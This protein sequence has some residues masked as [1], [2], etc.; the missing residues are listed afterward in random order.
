MFPPPVQRDTAD[1]DHRRRQ[2][3]DVRDRRPHGGVSILTNLL[4]MSHDDLVANIAV[5]REGVPGGRAPGRRPRHADAPHVRRRRRS[6]RCGAK[7][8][9]AVPRLPADV[10]RPHQQGAVGDGP[11][12]AKPD[13]RRRPPAPRRWTS[14]SSSPDEM[15]AI[16]DH[17]FERYFG[18]AGLFG[19]P[20]SCLALV[21]R[22]ARPRRRRDR[23]PDRLRRRRRRRCSTASTP[24][25]STLRRLHDAG[26]AGA[27]GARR[28]R[29][30]RRQIRRH[31][32]THLQCTPSLAACWSPTTE[33]LDALGSLRKLL[34]GGEAL[35]ASLVDGWPRG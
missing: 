15:A 33:A 34:L 29:D 17:A 25:G 12:F 8:R 28:R 21:D 6:T 35:P 19:T 30:R 18:T 7:V 1:V 16:M 32:V 20:E 13:D 14:T 3:R 27:D 24:P 4:V 26:T 10:D 23:L 11:A 31:G 22:P 9:G 2:S 5:Y